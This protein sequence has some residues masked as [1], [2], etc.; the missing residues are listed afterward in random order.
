MSKG[1]AR[2][3]WLTD[4]Q[5]ES[6]RSE[7]KRQGRSISNYV[8]YLHRVRG[9][10]EPAEDYP[11]SLKEESSVTTVEDVDETVVKIR[12]IKEEPDQSWRKDRP[13]RPKGE[14]G[15]SKK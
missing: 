10:G 7:A 14:D 4:E 9:E 3:I 1:K 13:S 8:T 5:W 2:S 15:K 12:G 11:P 6:F